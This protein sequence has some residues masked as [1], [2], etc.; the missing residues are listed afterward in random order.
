[1]NLPRMLR[2]GLAPA[3]LSLPLLAGLATGAQAQNPNLYWDPLAYAVAEDSGTVNIK[4]IPTRTLSANLTF[5]YSLG[6]TATPGT[7]YTIAGADYTART[8]T[9]TLP[10]GTQAFAAVD[11]PITLIDD[12]A[13]DNA[14]TI[15]VTLT[16]GNGY[17]I[18]GGA[19]ATL[20]IYEDTG[21][22]AF[23]LTGAPRVGG[24]LTVTRD[25]SDP[26]GDGALG[27]IWQRRER[28]DSGSWR[29]ITGETSSTYTLAQEDV[30]KY[31]RAWAGYNDGLGLRTSVATAPVGPV[32]AR[33]V[34]GEVR[35]GTPTP[36]RIAEGA[37]AVVGIGVFDADGDRVSGAGQAW[38]SVCFGGKAKARYGHRVHASDDYRLEVSYDVDGEGG[39][40]RDTWWHVPLGRQCGRNG[41]GAHV[42]LY[43]SDTRLR[44]TA[45]GDHRAEGEETAVLRVGAAG[46]HRLPWE[47]ERFASVSPGGGA[48]TVVIEPSAAVGPAASFAAGASSAAEDAGTHRVRVSLSRAAPSALRL[49]Y[50]VSG[51]ATAGTDY[52]ALP[53]T[54]A[55]A[56]GATEVDIAVALTDD[57]EDER[58]ETVILTLAGGAGYTVGAASE[59]TL[60][61]ADDDVPAA[62]FAAAT[63]SAAEDAGT[64]TVRVNL[65]PAPHTALAL[66]YTVSGT[67]TAGAD[68]TALA[69]TV[70]VPAGA[71]EVDIAVALTDDGTRES[72]ETLTL[73][74]ADGAGYAVGA[75]GA[76]TLA[77]ADDD[78]AGP[79]VLSV[80][81]DP[82]AGPSRPEDHTGN[83]VLVVAP[84][85]PV[86][87]NVFFRACFGGSA[88]RDAD[89]EVHLGTVKPTG[90][91]LG[92]RVSAG[93]ASYD[94]MY[95]KLLD[96]ADD[97]PYETVVVT[98]SAHPD[99]ALPAGVELAADP[100]ATFTIT[101][102]DDPPA[103]TPVVRITGGDAVTEGGNARFILTASPK[104]T[105]PIGVKVAVTERGRFAQGGQTGVR[106]VAVGPSGT[107]GFTVTTDDDTTA[108]ANGAI[109]ATLG[110]GS[111]Y[112]PHNTDAHASVAV[113]DDDTPPPGTPVVRI[114]G[115]PTVT[116]GGSAR[117][118]LTASPKPTSTIQV[119]VDV[120]QTGSFA[121]GGQTGVRTVPVGTSGTADFTVG[122]V[123]DTTEEADGA[124]TATVDTGS[125]YAPHNTDASASVRVNDDD[126][127]LW[128]SS[129]ADLRLPLRL[130]RIAGL[131]PAVAVDSKKADGESPT[132]SFSRCST[133]GSPAVACA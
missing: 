126:T 97:E 102:D 20:T 47:P 3:L 16:S 121:Q 90:G 30:G 39:Y 34:V 42:F 51:T 6:G 96:D 74:L 23:S 21:S 1:M 33:P 115:G 65:S 117:F 67:A 114:A 119:S 55:V 93:A 12:S 72:E 24:T 4:V 63:S 53:G 43:G 128:A 131:W 11:F 98:L 71:T 73:T 76:H 94:R 9:F 38:A 61:I 132:K 58:D 46:I 18:G 14:E 106:T 83:V 127:P 108:E 66:G 123:D 25:A 87:E 49:A 110:A 84:S 92:T 77:I 59:H 57:G 10:S 75:T 32:A 60:T 36:A 48:V 44:L 88:T 107:G 15:I 78:A 64:H 35:L 5:N 89:Y 19:L 112:S 120:G 129:P 2:S 45:I 31:I 99:H 118:T 13:T 103:T 133:A 17:G 109:T 116:E 27:Y 95:L 79:V 50:A 70:A 86:A 85:A 56:A 28:L 111:G 41:L 52:T 26:D 29:G 122:T 105:S 8:G 62:S 81:V 100:S 22:A 130:R 113:H 80:R 37:S 124:V 104:P 68:Y 7:D 82:S 125:G 91:C 69:G 54:V 101:D 40:D